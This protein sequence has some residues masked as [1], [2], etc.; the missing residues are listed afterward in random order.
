MIEPTDE[1]AKARSNKLSDTWMINP[2]IAEIF[3][4]LLDFG[5]S[6]H[7]DAVAEQIARRRSRAAPS[8]GF[9]REIVEAFDVH[10]DRARVSGLPALMYLPFGDNSQRWSLT[11]QVRQFADRYRAAD[12][13]LASTL[14][15]ADRQSADQAGPQPAQLARAR[16]RL[17]NRR[18]RDA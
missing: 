16:P 1:V 6:A 17:A 4:V 10:C 13:T 3:Q 12:G 18:P 14:S 5:G 11:P 15:I 2:L 9:K 8:A 7:R